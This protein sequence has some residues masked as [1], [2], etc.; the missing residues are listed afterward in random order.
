MRR[1]SLP[2]L[3]LCLAL[4]AA[5]PAQ[6]KPAL[7][8]GDTR[9]GFPLTAIALSPDGKLLVSFDSSTQ[10]VLLVDVATRKTLR[11]LAGHAG[12]VNQIAFSP[13]GR[14]LYTGGRPAGPGLPGQ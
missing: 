11:R 8:L 7:V 3:A 13:D 10:Q 12:F 14:R 1:L 4:T 9:F 5:T 2:A 6:A